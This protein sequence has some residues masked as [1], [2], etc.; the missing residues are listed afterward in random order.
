MLNR[1][2]LGPEGNDPLA[3][4]SLSFPPVAGLCHVQVLVSALD[5]CGRRKSLELG[6]T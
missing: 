5:P 2:R 6:F 1:C 4:W 3:G